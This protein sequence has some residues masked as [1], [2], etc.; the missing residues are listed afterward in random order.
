MS[1]DEL[2]TARRTGSASGSH[3]PPRLAAAIAYFPSGTIE[4]SCRLIRLAMISLLRQDF[5]AV[6][7]VTHR[8]RRRAGGEIAGHHKLQF[9]RRLPEE[10]AKVFSGK[11]F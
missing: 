7:R 6:I 9:F 10:S 8:C 2:P 3:L 5:F 4:E 11:R 1:T